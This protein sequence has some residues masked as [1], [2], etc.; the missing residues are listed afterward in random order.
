VS[1]VLVVAGASI[2]TFDRI[3]KI[4]GSLLAPQGEVISLPLRGNDADYTVKYV[5]MLV[6]ATSKCLL[7]RSEHEPVSVLLL[8][9]NVSNGTEE[10]LLDAFF[11]MA[12]PLAVDLL[13]QSRPGEP[14]KRKV[15]EKLIIAGAHKLR[16]VFPQVSDKTRVANL[17]PLLLPLRNF[18]SEALALMLRALYSELGRHAAPGDLIVEKVARFKARHPPTKPPSGSQHCYTDGHLFFRSPGRHRHGF[19][20]NSSRG[21]HSDDCILRARSR[22]GGSIPYTMHYDCTSERE[23]AK[24]YPNCHCEATPPKDMHVNIGPSDFII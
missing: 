20:R 16:E 18:R 3:S 23:L 22:L 15:I 8:Y 11:P 5:R 4:S 2:A 14:I 13:D 10:I 9:L 24:A 12:L 19:F 6:E 17:S 1:Y 7:K 21:T